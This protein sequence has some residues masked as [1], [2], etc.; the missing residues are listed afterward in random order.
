MTTQGRQRNSGPNHH[1]ANAQE[2]ALTA[3]SLRKLGYHYEEIARRCGYADRAVAWNAVQ[4]LLARRKV[5]GVAQLRQIEGE[6]LDDIQRAF[7]VRAMKGE[8]KAALVVLRIMERRAKLLGLDITPEEEGDKGII[9]EYIGIDPAAIIGAGN[10]ASAPTL[11]AS[12]GSDTAA[13]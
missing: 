8:D 2:R 4:R 6:G 10:G 7:M 12:R 3:L 1:D 5:E 11:R 13:E 9:R